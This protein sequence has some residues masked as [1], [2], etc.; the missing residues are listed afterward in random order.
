[1]NSWTDSAASSCAMA[2]ETDDWA[3]GMFSAASVTLPASQVATKYSSWRRV[4]R[5]AVIA[6]E[7]ATTAMPRSLVARD[8]EGGRAVGVQRAGHVVLA[9]GRVVVVQGDEVADRVLA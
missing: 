6:P 4:K 5:M 1:M 7:S 9:Q 3:T 8:A 2:A